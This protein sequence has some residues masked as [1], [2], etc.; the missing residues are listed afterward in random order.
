MDET[1]IYPKNKL[2]TLLDVHKDIQRNHFKLWLN[3][4]AIF[5]ELINSPLYERA[6]ALMS[7]IKKDYKYY[8][9]NESLNKSLEILNNHQFMIISGIP[10]IGKTTL[11]KLLLMEY[12]LNGY[13]IMEIRKIA[14]GE[15]LLLEDSNNKQ[16]FYFDNFLGEN[17]L[18]YDVIEGRSNDLVQFIKRVMSNKNKILIMTTREYILQ[19]AKQ[20]YEKLDSDEFD[21]YK[22]TLDLNTYSKRIKTMILYNHLYYSGLSEMYITNLIKDNVYKRII[23]HKNYSPRIIE[24]M[25]VKLKNTPPE[26]YAEAFIDSLD[27][28]FKIWDKAFNGQISDGSKFTLYILLSIGEK[29]LLADFKSALDCFN[30][31]VAIPK[32]Y[33][34]NPLDYKNYL[35]ELEGSFIKVNVTEQDH[36]FIDFQNPSVKDFLLSFIS[37]DRDIIKALLTSAYYFKQF[38]YT[39]DYLAKPYYEDE[40][41]AEIIKI[42]VKDQFD[43]FK[44]NT[45]IFIHGKEINF[46]PNTMEKIFSLRNYLLKSKEKDTLAYIL[47]KFRSIDIRS[48]FYDKEKMYIQ[49]YLDF[50]R[51]LKMDYI[52]LL[53]NLIDNISWMENAKNITL[54]SDYDP[55][56]YDKTL[57][58]Q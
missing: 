34:F 56:L 1:H 54:L 41:I 9:K 25:T 38:V 26:E 10:G 45:Y 39:I 33:N 30:H 46:Q 21:V 57:Q 44:N 37:D 17:F 20:T 32:G 58:K 53:E 8:V 22:Y 2:N 19:Q 35:K 42:V 55:E 14:E 36:H 15:Q 50:H 3:S 31:K 24:G 7:D 4:A 48:L 49:F 5:N 43:T 6:K 12:L 52:T 40:A 27:K 23:A 47:D 11:A 28:P 13:E 18:K 29:I 51:Q 16:V